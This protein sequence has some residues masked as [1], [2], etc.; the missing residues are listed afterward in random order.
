MKTKVMLNKLAKLFPKRLAEPYDFPGLQV[1]KLK[2]ETNVVLL[3]LDF[4][5]AV[6]NYIYENKLEDKI[7]LIITH[8]PFIFGE[9]SDIL[10]NDPHK[11]YLYNELEKHNIP[12]YSFHTNFDSGKLGMNDV[13][14]ELLELKNCRRLISEPMACGGELPEPMDVKDFAKYAISKLHVDYGLLLDYGSPTIQSVAIIGGGGWKGYKNAQLESYDIFIS[15]DIP[16]HGR[17]DIVENKYNYLDVPHEVENA[18]MPQ[19]KKILLSFD[20]SMEIICL[21]QE[22]MP[23]VICN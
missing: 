3:C 20:N 8:H 7:D 18:F 10:S 23:K 6:L 9:K 5:T 22:Q 4:D 17:R 14:A 13:L 16:H 2:E 11:N 1:G 12:I 19:M 15:G 21:F